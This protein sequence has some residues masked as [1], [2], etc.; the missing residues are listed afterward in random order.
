MELFKTEPNSIIKKW[1]S[2]RCKESLKEKIESILKSEY[3]NKN[4]IKN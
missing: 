1:F 2:N 4:N 3:S